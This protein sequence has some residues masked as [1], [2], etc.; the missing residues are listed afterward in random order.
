MWRE[1]VGGDGGAGLGSA[2]DDG[3]WC[4]AVAL[5][6]GTWLEAMLVTVLALAATAALLTGATVGRGLGVLVVT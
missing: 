4:A 6:T 2:G 5:V 1:G 3:V